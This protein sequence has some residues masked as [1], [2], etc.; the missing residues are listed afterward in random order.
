MYAIDKFHKSQN[1]PFHMMAYPTMLQLEQKYADFCFEWSIMGY[2]TDAFWDMWIRSIHKYT[3]WNMQ[4]NF[5]WLY[6][7][8]FVNCWDIFT[9]IPKS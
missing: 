3:P 1:A 6:Y 7:K 5:L 2:G 8:S 9:H 4:P